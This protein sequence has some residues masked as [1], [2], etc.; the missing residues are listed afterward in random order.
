[1]LY[2]AQGDRG[3]TDHL[4]S[5]TKI[6]KDSP[7]M[8]ALGALDEI[9]SFLGLCKVKSDKETSIVLHE[10]QNDLFTIQAEIAGSMK[11]VGR[12]R[13]D[14][15]EHE[16][17]LIEKDLP[18]IHTFFVAGSTEPS[19]LFDYA[20]T[21]ARRAER[22]VVALLAGKNPFPVQLE[23]LSYLNRLS[24]LLYAFARR[25]ASKSGINEQPPEYR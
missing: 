17:D 2:S 18:E 4:S 13:T 1:M 20:R 25:E 11:R 10:V 9:N 7:V 12:D 22:A 8:E 21:I 16:I 19:A 14:F 5:A 24:S 6:S 3:T 23:T 15:L